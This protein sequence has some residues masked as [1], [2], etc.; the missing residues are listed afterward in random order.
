MLPSVA[1]RAPSLTMPNGD[2]STA[3]AST[4]KTGVAEGLL[5]RGGSLS[6]FVEIHEGLVEEAE[7]LGRSWRLPALHFLSHTTEV[8]PELC[9]LVTEVLH[10]GP[11]RLLEQM[12]AHLQPCLGIGAWTLIDSAMGRT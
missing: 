8:P 6:G 1:V 3:W 2:G 7:L 4:P 9:E 12:P 10:C 11:V 5:R